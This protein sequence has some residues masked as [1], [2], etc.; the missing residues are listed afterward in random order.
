MARRAWAFV[1]GADSPDATNVL[2]LYPGTQSGNVRLG[3][4][5]HTAACAITGG[6]VYRGCAM[7]D[8]HGTSG[9][10]GIA[11]PP[12]PHGWRQHDGWQPW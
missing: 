7:P 2:R 5:D 4:D 12:Q 11:R 6:Y 10:R 1:P 9:S 8:L 3:V